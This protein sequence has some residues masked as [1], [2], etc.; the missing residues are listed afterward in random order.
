MNDQAWD[1]VLVRWW[2]RVT[3]NLGKCDSGKGE[4]EEV[5]SEK[6]RKSVVY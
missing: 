6:F 4:V 2:F 3:G 1:T 5:R